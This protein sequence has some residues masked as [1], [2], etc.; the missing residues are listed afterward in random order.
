MSSDP[1]QAAASPQLA[2]LSVAYHGTEEN[3]AEAFLTGIQTLGDETAAQYHEYA[4]AMSPQSVRDLLRRIM[5]TTHWPVYSDMAKELPPAPM[6]STS[7][8]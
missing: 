5:A 3:V 6:S 4:V 8:P 2:V 1:D 7:P